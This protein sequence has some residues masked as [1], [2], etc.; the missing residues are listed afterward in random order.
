MFCS[1]CGAPVELVQPKTQKRHDM[2]MHVNV[3]AWIFVGAAGL[4]GIGGVIALLAGRLI[5]RVP[6]E[7]PPDVPPDM[8]S[9]IASLLLFGGLVCLL[10]AAGV[11]AAGIGLL[12][13]ENWGR[14]AA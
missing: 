5:T 4:I 3:L 12:R 11:A 13:Y 9:L 6:I 10:L 7:W 8:V 14:V 1:N 2:D